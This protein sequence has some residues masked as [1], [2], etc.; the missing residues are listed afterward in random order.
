MQDLFNQKY[1]VNLFNPEVSYYVS[2]ASKIF[3]YSETPA[4][5][6]PVITATF[7]GRVVKTAIHFLVKKTVIDTATP[8]ILP[9]FFG[10]LL[11]VLRG[12][13]CM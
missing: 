10:P 6:H 13:H 9:D 7:F 8:L 11:T 12:V 1:P 4:Y 5:G 2:H 3:F